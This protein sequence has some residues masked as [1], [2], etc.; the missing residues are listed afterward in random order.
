M[1]T[2]TCGVFARRP[3]LYG[4]FQVMARYSSRTET[5]TN[6]SVKEIITFPENTT[7]APPFGRTLPIHAVT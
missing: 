1:I 5:G 6:V 2:E 3:L 7:E 4:A